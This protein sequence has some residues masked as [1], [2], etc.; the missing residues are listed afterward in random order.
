[1][2]DIVFA[3]G[4]GE[5]ILLDEVFDD[6]K[7]GRVDPIHLLQLLLLL[8]QLV[9]QLLVGPNE[10]YPLLEKDCFLV[11]GA[12]LCTGFFLVDIVLDVVLVPVDFD[13]EVLQVHLDLLLQLDVAADGRLHLLGLQL[14]GLVAVHAD[15]VLGKQLDEVADQVVGEGLGGA[16]QLLILVQPRQLRKI[17]LC[18][19]HPF[20]GIQDEILRLFEQLLGRALG[21]VEQ[22]LK[23]F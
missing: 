3:F 19:E 14:Q 21:G 10:A 17:V 7:V 12:M 9:H 5:F 22:I 16:R 13:L 20:Q 11:V 8:P 1:M 4:Y 18:W 23:L 15:E 6:A 2:L